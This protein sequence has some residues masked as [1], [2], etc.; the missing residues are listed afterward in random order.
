[1]IELVKNK[2]IES[3]FDK[4]EILVIWDHLVALLTMVHSS[5]ILPEGMVMY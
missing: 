1:M 3:S 2:F 4:L 5:A